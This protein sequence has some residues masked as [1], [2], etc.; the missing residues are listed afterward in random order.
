LHFPLPVTSL[1]T[2]QHNN[3]PLIV[4][5]QK[6]KYSCWNFV[7]ILSLEANIFH[8]RLLI[9]TCHLYNTKR[10]SL[11]GNVGIAVKNVFP[12]SEEYTL[13]IVHKIYILLLVFSRHFGHL[14]DAGLVLLDCF[15]HL[16]ALSYSGKFTEAFSLTPSTWLRNGI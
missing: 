5:P 14:V 2:V 13:Y 3:Y 1:L 8:F 16:V 10:M 6:H 11:A 7:A 4:G 9:S 12:P 15:H